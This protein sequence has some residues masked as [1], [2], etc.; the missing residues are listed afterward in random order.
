MPRYYLYKNFLRF[1]YTGNTT[2]S[3]TGRPSG[4]AEP[5]ERQVIFNDFYRAFFQ[6]FSGF[7]CSGSDLF[8]IGVPV[9]CSS[10]S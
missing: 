9:P 5:L 10:G 2:L 4:G 3:Q 6:A 8:F 1:L 7:F